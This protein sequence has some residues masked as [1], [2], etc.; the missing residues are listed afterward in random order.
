MNN[1]VLVVLEE[2]AVAR[3]GH[4]VP[5]KLK[6]WTENQ[7]NKQRKKKKQRENESLKN[8]PT[9][10]CLSWDMNT[11]PTNC[12]EMQEKESWKTPDIKGYLFWIT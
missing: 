11:S 9:N 1:F 4:C 2:R 7:T 10:K 5:E 12:D 8:M 6:K 3:F